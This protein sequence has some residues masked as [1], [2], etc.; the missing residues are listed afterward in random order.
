MQGQFDSLQP[1][2][3]HLYGSLRDTFPNARFLVL[4]D[5][6]LFPERTPP[7][8]RLGDADCTLLLERWTSSEREAIRGWGLTLN[9][10]IQTSAAEAGIDY[11]D[12]STHFVGH[13]PC[14][15]ADDCVRFVGLSTDSAVRDGSFHPLRAG[16]EMMARII[17]CYLRV[18]ST[19][20]VTRT[21]TTD[22]AMT[23]CVASETGFV[24]EPPRH[25][26]HPRGK[27]GPR[28]P[29]AIKKNGPE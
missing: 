18:F 19:P 16:Q 29:S 23:G 7:V 15:S 4:G 13:E 1:Q 9:T 10:L 27:D 20:D 22:F 6:S 8:T 26:R 14:G 2:L 17:S 3:V 28:A 21:E 5:P 12:V 24:I 11:I 25:R